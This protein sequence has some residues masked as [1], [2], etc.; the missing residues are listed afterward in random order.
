MKQLMQF[1]PVKFKILRLVVC[2]AV[3]V[4]AVNFADGQCFDGA[5]YQTGQGSF[6]ALGCCQSFITSDC[7][8]FTCYDS[9]TCCQN[10][11]GSVSCW[12]SES[13]Q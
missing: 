7:C 6:C 12:F 9:W 2:I 3:G 13:C 1:S 10:F 8:D 4:A 11:D 5:C